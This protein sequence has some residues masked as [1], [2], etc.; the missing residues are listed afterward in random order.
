VA[1]SI[2]IASNALIL[3][4]DDPITSFSEDS[5]GATA[6]ANLYADT[7]KQ[8]L[9]EHP[10]TFALKELQLSRLS[11]SPDDETGYH[12]AFQMPAD[13]IR[14][15][16]LF[17]YANYTIVGN[18]IYSNST[19]L[20]ARYVYNVS[21]SLLPAHM[22][23]T[24]EYRLAADF[25]MLITESATKAQYYEEKYRDMLA[26]AKSIDSQNRPQQPIIDSPFVDVRMSGR[27][28]F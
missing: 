10:W 4:G 17:P 25:A 20:L 3:I 2:D 11:Q 15:W 18:L 9:A 23:K 14:L 6:A 27:S 21:E 24:L 1:T 7:F 5:A 22:I 16:A 8:V 12:Y 19:E 26:K 13:L 28:Y